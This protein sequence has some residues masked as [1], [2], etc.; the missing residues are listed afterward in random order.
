VVLFDEIEKAHPEVLNVL[1][2]L[3]DDG[4]LTDGK[5]RT[6]DFKNTVI[7]MTSN[8]GSQ[9]IAERTRQEATELDEGTRRLV[10]DALRAHFPPEFLN[11]VDDVIVFHPLGRE[12]LK[13]IV[14]IQLKGLTRRLEDRKISLQLTDAARLRLVEE[15]YD[16][17]YGARP[18]KRTIQRLLLDPLAMRVLQGDFGEGDVVR[19]DAG[20][21]G[22][23]FEKAPQQATIER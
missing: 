12:H 22:L 15:G 23:T 18:L 4:R 17:T 7:I 19:V 1:L 14:D 20:P 9:Y 21:S 10:V 13:Q 11:R 6:V 8:L 3:L 16:P 5:G 2:Q